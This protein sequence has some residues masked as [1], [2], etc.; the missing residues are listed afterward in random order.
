MKSTENLKDRSHTKNKFENKFV[1]QFKLIKKI[2]NLILY[3]GN[4][5]HTGITLHH[6]PF[7]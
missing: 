4:L 2:L 3:P 1:P 5:T 6:R 7:A